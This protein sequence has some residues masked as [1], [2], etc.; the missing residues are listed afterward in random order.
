MERFCGNKTIR[1]ERENILEI[2]LTGDQT[3]YLLFPRTLVL[4]RW[5]YLTMGASAGITTGASQLDLGKENGGRVKG[6]L[7][8]V[9]HVVNV[10][11]HP[12]M[13]F[14]SLFS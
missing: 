5:I 7:R 2:H 4:G 13:D 3:N 10:P 1:L 11:I 12:G 14:I 6:D 8:P 9:L